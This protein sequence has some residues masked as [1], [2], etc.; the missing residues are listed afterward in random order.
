MT[1]F[2]CPRSNAVGVE[3]G[4]LVQ[5][6][7]ICGMGGAEYM[8]TVTTMM[9]ANKEVERGATLRRVASR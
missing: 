9:L 4:V 2:A 8:P 5:G 1:S 6:D 3:F 7:G